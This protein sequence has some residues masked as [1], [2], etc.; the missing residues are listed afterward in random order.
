MT[1]HQNAYFERW[2]EANKDKVSARRKKKYREDKGFRDAMLAKAA[3]RR[4]SV[5]APTPDGFMGIVEAAKMLGVSAYVLRHWLHKEYFPQPLVLR[6]KMLLSEEQVKRL[7]PLRNFISGRR[8]LS[9]AEEYVLSDIISLIF[10]NW[11]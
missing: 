2:Y 6:N 4:E 9:H 1:M 8:K 7:V 11:V 5:R 10:I 3:K